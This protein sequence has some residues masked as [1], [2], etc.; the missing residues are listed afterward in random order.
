MLNKG[1]T[2]FGTCG[3]VQPLLQLFKMDDLTLT[4]MLSHTGMRKEPGLERLS[5]VLFF[6]PFVTQLFVALFIHTINSFQGETVR[7][8]AP[9]S[10]YHVPRVSIMADCLDQ[11][12]LLISNMEKLHSTHS[13]S[14][15]QP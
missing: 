12:S 3:M 7:K 9:L 11:A 4:C 10:L 13:S 15:D 5:L 6:P 8:C 1:D 2:G 14:L